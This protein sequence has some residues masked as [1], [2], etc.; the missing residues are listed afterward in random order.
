MTSWSSVL[1]DFDKTWLDLLLLFRKDGEKMEKS[2]QEAV[3]IDRIE[4]D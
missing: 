1:I 4:R 2:Q 3:H